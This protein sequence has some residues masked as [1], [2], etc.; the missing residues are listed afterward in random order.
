M[1]TE[2]VVFLSSTDRPILLQSRMFSYLHRKIDA[3]DLIAM[4]LLGLLR[5]LSWSIQFCSARGLL[6]AEYIR[7]TSF[8]NKEFT[9]TN[10]GDMSA[11]LYLGY[12]RRRVPSG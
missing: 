10:L 4:L 9:D 12:H 2:S 7:W 6:P 5:L 8:G 1:V 11:Y 3:S